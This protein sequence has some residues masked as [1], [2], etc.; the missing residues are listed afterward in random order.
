M[1]EAQ[2]KFTTSGDDS[3]H[4]ADRACDD[5][6]AEWRTLIERSNPNAVFLTTSFWDANAKKLDNAD[7]FRLIYRRDISGP[8]IA[9]AVEEGI[10]ILTS[11]GA[12]VY[13][14]NSVP[15]LGSD[16]PSAEAMS[17]TVTSIYEDAKKAGKN[18]G[19]LDLRGQVCDGRRCPTSIR[20]IAVLDETGHPAGESL[21]RLSRWMLNTVSADLDA[22]QR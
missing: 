22:V 15:Y 6:D 9:A 11:R 7:R 8:G 5:W 4:D 19:L 20:G 1:R 2:Y 21:A 16:L 10:D 17:E 14:D 12:R 18:V 3:P 13:L